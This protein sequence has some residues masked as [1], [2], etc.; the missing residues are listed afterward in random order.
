MFLQIR[1]QNFQT[2][3]VLN[4]PVEMPLYTWIISACTFLAESTSYKSRPLLKE[5]GGSR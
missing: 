3:R 4:C 1:I 2:K 5:A